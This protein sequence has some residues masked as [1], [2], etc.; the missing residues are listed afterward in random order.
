MTLSKSISLKEYSIMEYLHPI[1][2]PCG[3]NYFSALLFLL[4]FFCSDK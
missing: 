4:F 1:F 3:G 2:N